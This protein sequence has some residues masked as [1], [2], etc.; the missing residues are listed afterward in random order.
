[1]LRLTTWVVKGCEVAS[2]C[3]NARRRHCE[4]DTRALMHSIVGIGDGDGG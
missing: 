4:N 2:N 1:M 3:R